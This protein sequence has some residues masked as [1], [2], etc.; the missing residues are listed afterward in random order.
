MSTRP[1]ASPVTLLRHTGDQWRGT[2]DSLD[3]RMTFYLML[4]P[5][6]S[7]ITRAFLRNPERNLGAFLRIDRLER[8]GSSVKLIG[9]LSRDGPE[10]TVVEGLF[11]STGQR[12]SLDFPQLGG[13]FDFERADAEAESRFYP[14]GRNSAP[15]AY[16]SPPARDDGWSVGTV[17]EVG[18]DRDRISAF[19]QHLIDT[20]IDSLGSSDIHGVLIARHGRLVL[21]EYFHG[22]GRDRAHDTRSAA[23]SLTAVLTGAAILAGASFDTS[24][25]IYQALGI[26]DSDLRKHAMTLE[27]LL[28]MSSG[29]FCDDSNPD[30][31]G[32]EDRMQE[33]TEEP[34]WWRYTLNVPMAADPGTVAVYCSGNPNL[35]GALMSRATGQWLPELFRDRV[36]RPLGI[37][38]YFL[39]L[40]PT[41]DAYLGGGMYFKPRDFMKLGQLAVNGGVWKGRRVVSQAWIER[42]ISPL[43]QIGNRQKRRYGYLWWIEDYPYRGRTVRAAF[44]GG[45]GGQIVMAIPELDLVIAFYGGNYNDPALFIPQR[46]LVPEY[47]LPAVAEDAR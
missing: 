40:M 25:P 45:N 20:P 4:A 28:T 13:F 35:I 10:S 34:D 44:A 42:A 6:V 16:E 19:V 39:N 8:A 46:V 27:H 41:G 31:L 1:F 11:D 14:R 24:T 12:L 22:F 18:I 23:K 2:V 33:Q 29:Y 7:G 38:H 43:V 5:D 36:A 30:A 21:E 47:I 9:R 26:S 32:S 3:E 37:E 15:Y 17:E